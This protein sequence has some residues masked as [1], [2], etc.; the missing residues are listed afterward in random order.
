MSLIRA[1]RKGH[2]RGTVAHWSGEPLTVYERR[3]QVAKDEMQ[4]YDT[5]CDGYACTMKPRR[6]ASLYDDDSQQL[7]FITGARPRVPH[8]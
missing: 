4:N 8:A 6:V 7:D 3:K 5:P 1:R 2:C